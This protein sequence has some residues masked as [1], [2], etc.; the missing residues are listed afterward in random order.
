MPINIFVIRKKL[1]CITRNCGMFVIVDGKIRTCSHSQPCRCVKW[2]LTSLSRF[3]KAHYAPAFVLCAIICIRPHS[4][5]TC[6][7]CK[8]WCNLLVRIIFFGYDIVSRKLQIKSPL[9]SSS[10]SFGGASLP[11]QMEGPRPRVYPFTTLATKLL[12]SDADCK[13]LQPASCFVIQNH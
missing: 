13:G 6:I 5:A 8:E 10:S 3:W 4:P 11:R 9:Y 12:G 2:S 1:L 7:W